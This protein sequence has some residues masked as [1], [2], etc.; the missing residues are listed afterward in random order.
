VRAGGYRKG[1]ANR[2]P[3]V[4]V[5]VDDDPSSRHLPRGGSSSGA[6]AP[7]P[8]PERRQSPR[9]QQ[10]PPQQRGGGA[11]ASPSFS[12]LQAGAPHAE[13]GGLLGS[14]KRG[15]S[16]ASRLGTGDAPSDASDLAAEAAAAAAAAAGAADDA[17]SG[18]VATLASAG[19]LGERDRT[20]GRAGAAETV[21]LWRGERPRGMRLGGAGAT[22]GAAAVV[23]GSWWGERV[24][25]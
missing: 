6:G 22:A 2:Q 17:G 10:P 12:V 15:R 11:A 18:G 9:R 24:V 7:S 19:T 13:G 1:P 4:D 14:G 25:V 21:G 8:S 16:A 5:I 20:G 3:Q 23:G